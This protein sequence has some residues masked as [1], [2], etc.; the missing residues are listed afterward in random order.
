MFG[1]AL[2]GANTAS[3]MYDALLPDVSTPATRGRVSGLGV[4][5]GYLGSF[6]GLGIFFGIRNV[7]EATYGVAFVTLGCAFLIFSLPAFLF[8]REPR[9]PRPFGRPP[10]LSETVSH[11]VAA[12]RH[13]SGYPGVV[14][15]LMARFLYADAL[16]TLVGVL[17]LFATQE[18]GFGEDM[19]LALIAIAIAAAIP[20]GLVAGRLV[21]RLG[22]R[23]VLGVALLMMTTGMA[24]AIVAAVANQPHLAWAIGP[25][26]GMALG[27]IGASDRVLMARISP[28]HHLGEFYGLYAT[29]GRFSAIVGPLLWGIVVDNLGFGRSAAM[30]VL[31]CFVLTALWVL[32]RVDDRER[33]WDQQDLIGARD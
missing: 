21:E 27:A 12:W 3:A 9:R 22:P 5:V 14:R 7:L 25:L 29:I 4:G 2:I 11:L 6:I 17:T 32:R 15:F 18:L 30:G 31:I 23:K 24:A 20:G 28:P 33:V 1:I 13:A 16:T 8:I 19:P 10:G 26:G